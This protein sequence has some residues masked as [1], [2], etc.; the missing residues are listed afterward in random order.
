PPVIDCQ[1]LIEAPSTF[2]DCGASIQV[3]PPAAYDECNSTPLSY[4][5]K[6]NGQVILPEAG[7]YYLPLLNIGQYTITWEVR[8]A[9][10]NLATCSSQIDLFD[11]TPPVA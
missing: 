6:L 4:K 1:A 8:D 10:G 9:C 11:N 3:F 7:K 2:G 5:L